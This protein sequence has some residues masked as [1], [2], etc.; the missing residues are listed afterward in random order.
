MDLQH[1]VI[2]PDGN[3]RWA[4]K[5]LLD[6]TSGHQKGMERFEKLY[7]TIVEMKIPYF[8]FWGASYDNLTKRSESEIKNLL[9]LFHLEFSKL[10]KDER[11]M[12]KGI[13]INVIGRWREIFPQKTQ[14]I[15]NECIKKT[16]N[17]QNLSLTF[18]L[19]YNGTDEMINA[20]KQIKE[21]NLEVTEENIK[22]NLLTK[23]LPPVDFVIRTGVDEDLHNS[24]GFMMWDTAYSQLY[25]TKTLFPDFDKEEL[26]KVINNFDLRERRYGK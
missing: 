15:I 18:L 19:A 17:N 23:D 3:R 25:F 22:N 12:E 8:S 6:P 2:I 1:L 4:K 10:L 16:E 9:N 26:V 21:K 13:K 20:I 7:E 24:A 14:E 5:N 11:V